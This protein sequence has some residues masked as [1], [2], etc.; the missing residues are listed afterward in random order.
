MNDDASVPISESASRRSRRSGLLLTAAAV[1]LA[2][3]IAV[4]VVAVRGPGRASSAP[5]PAHPFTLPE[6][7]HPGGSVSL[8]AYRGRPLIV[9]FF[10]S[11]CPPCKRET[12]LLARFYRQHHGR[13]IIVGVDA[14][15]KAGAA[16]R[17]LRAAG[18]SYPV[19]FD[20][21][22]ANTAVSYGVLA[23]PQTFFLDARHRIVKHVIGPVTARSLAQGVALMDGKG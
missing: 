21:Y 23:L 12:P 20:P 16:E 2:V 11:W 5:P 10:A 9:N 22:P 14:N 19:G 4:I 18:V 8:A 7:G 1:V 17:F 15:D 3:V 13:T 6:V